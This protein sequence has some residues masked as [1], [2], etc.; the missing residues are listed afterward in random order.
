VRRPA[1]VFQIGMVDIDGAASGPCGVARLQ[2][3]KKSIF[4]GKHAYGEEGVHCCAKRK[5]TM[6]RW[7]SSID[8]SAEFSIPV[9][10]EHDI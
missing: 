5:S 2:G 7:W 6:Q 4:G 10:H 9:K 3:R 8:N 1:V